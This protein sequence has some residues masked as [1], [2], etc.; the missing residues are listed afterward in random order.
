[1][2]NWLRQALDDAR[3]AIR[4]DSAN[5][6]AYGEL[7][8]GLAL[9]GD[10]GEAR[11]VYDASRR[12][13]PGS[14]YLA[15]LFIKRL[16]PR[17]G[18]SYEAM[19][20]FAAE[21]A[22]DSLINPR[23]RTFLG[24]A[25]NDIADMA[26]GRDSIMMALRHANASLRYGPELYYLVDRGHANAHFGDYARAITD[27]NAVLAQWPHFV[28]ALEN[29]AEAISY[30][31][32]Y[33][34]GGERSIV[35]KELISQYQLILSL[36]PANTWARNGLKDALYELAT[37]PEFAPECG[38]SQ[39]GVV[40]VVQ[41]VWR[42]IR[43][44]LGYLGVAGFISWRAYLRWA[45]SGFYLPRYVHLIA[46]LALLTIGYIQ[47]LWVLTGAPMTLRRWVVT[48]TLPLLVYILFIGLGGA[49][50]AQQA[51][52]PAPPAPRKP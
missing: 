9:A 46:L 13:Y 49:R 30:S 36:E 38:N 10:Q 48:A 25:E 41:S 8:D 31:A 6:N 26:I 51:R 50:H 3:E 24:A 52:A 35:L 23:L 40:S 34:R 7:L 42:D 2:E 29:H 12:A 19:N 14:H 11:T 17:W 33:V 39:A 43:W 22:A 27:L 1:M 20:A 37:C 47:R 21:I 15:H 5:Y 4:L 45:K 28:P 32:F 16:E 18:G 44:L